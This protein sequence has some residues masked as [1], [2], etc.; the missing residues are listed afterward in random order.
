MGLMPT[1]HVRLPYRLARRRTPHVSYVF[2]WVRHNSIL[3][4]GPACPCCRRKAARGPTSW[5]MKQKSLQSQPHVAKHSRVGGS[6]RLSSVF[7][8]ARKFAPAKQCVLP[9]SPLQR[10]HRCS[11]DTCITRRG[12][13]QTKQFS[14]MR[15]TSLVF[16][17]VVCPKNCWTRILRQVSQVCGSTVLYW[18][19]HR[20]SS[21]NATNITALN[22]LA[23]TP[24]DRNQIRFFRQTCER[25]QVAD[26]WVLLGQ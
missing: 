12:T 5:E 19:L 25:V 6:V 20:H 13:L 1:G 9:P 10:L 26:S 3:V 8:Y 17:V 4:K 18:C 15:K 2:V 21:R 11:L 24:H 22:A 14:A 23:A 16:I 7:R